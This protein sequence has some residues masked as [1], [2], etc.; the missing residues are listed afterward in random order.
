MIILRW[1]STKDDLRIR[2][3]FISMAIGT[4]GEGAPMNMLMNVS[5]PSEARNVFLR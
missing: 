3:G 5:V 4:K 1:I 2:T